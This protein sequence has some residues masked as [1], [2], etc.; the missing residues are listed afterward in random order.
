MTT[1][2]PADWRRAAPCRDEDPDLW[3]PEA[4]S[5]DRNW[6]TRQAKRICSS[7]PTQKPCLDWALRAPE[8]NG[9]WGGLDEQELRNRR[10]A[11][12]RHAATAV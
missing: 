6:R 5:P 11:D 7:C 1:T 8:R 10:R 2:D 3:F 12:R 4:D 9:I